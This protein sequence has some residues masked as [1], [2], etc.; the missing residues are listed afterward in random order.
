MPTGHMMSGQITLKE[1]YV[2]ILQFIIRGKWLKKRR[3]AVRDTG[4]IVPYSDLIPRYV[5][6]LLQ[7]EQCQVRCGFTTY[8]SRCKAQREI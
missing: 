2:G 1:G 6:H 8:P 3:Q 4:H 7:E 5:T